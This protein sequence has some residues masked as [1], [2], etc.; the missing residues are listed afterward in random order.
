MRIRLDVCLLVV[1]IALTA[2]T[3]AFCQA[4]TPPD[5]KP[6]DQDAALRKFWKM[7]DSTVV[8][9]TPG[10]TVTKGEVLSY[11]W[12]S[13]AGNALQDLLTNKAVEVAAKKAG[14]TA[15]PKE[16][17]EE[18][19]ETATR[20]R[21]SSI[22][23]LLVRYKMPRMVFDR[24]IKG[25]V[26]I[27][28]MLMKDTRI[29]REEYAQWVDARHIL[30]RFSD[31]EK[32]QAKRE[33][34]AKA[35]IDDIAKKL[36][37]GGDFAALAS[38]YSDD[39]GSKTNGGSLGWFTKGRMVPEFEQAA[40]TMKPGEVTR[41]PVKTTYGY[42]IIK[43]EKSGSAATAADRRELRKMITDQKVQQERG[44][45]FSE[46][47]ANTKME[48]RLTG[49]ISDPANKPKPPAPR[50]APAPA[51]RPTTPPEGGDS[52]PPPAP[53]PAPAPPA[54]E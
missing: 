12:Y 34:D 20:M 42:H 9:S 50:P 8:G 37:D 40:F 15:S 22:D 7:P 36:A 48:N 51:P 38:E 6:F 54:G 24:I 31:A 3:A 53:E 17:E 52:A 4:P 45:W 47:L 14:V 1:V 19:L 30:V 16:I 41:E 33:A 43:V 2:T 44:R 27:R 28:K 5:E 35:K 32:D 10:A 39:P 49:V 26:L 18:A 13:Q 46:L 23:E 11:L 21:A 25:N 29:T